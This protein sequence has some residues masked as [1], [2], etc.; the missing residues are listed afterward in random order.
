MITILLVEDDE[1]DTEAVERA[2]DQA[3]ISNPIRVA[4]DGIEALQILRGENGHSQIKKPFIAFVDLNMPRMDGI[5][6]VKEMRKDENLRDT[7]VFILTTSKADEDKMKAYEQN[8]AGYIPKNA[9][10][11]GFRKAAEMLGAYWQAVELP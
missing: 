10:G 4:K 3:K 5:E 2:L 11:G 8:V 6:C 1:V 9:V 7:I